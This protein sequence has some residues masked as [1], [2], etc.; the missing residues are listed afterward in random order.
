M[1][2][3]D[4]G[5]ISVIDPVE[6]Y[7]PEYKG[8]K[9]RGCHGT[10]GYGCEGTAPSRP[11]NI[12]D[13]MEHTSG[14]ETSSSSRGGPEPTTLADLAALGAK[15]QLLFDPGTRWNYSNLGYNVLG[16]IIEVVSKQSYDVFLKERIFDPLGMKDT[17]FFVPQEKMNRVATLYTL[18]DSGLTRSPNQLNTQQGPKIPMP[19][20]GIVSTAEDILR[21]NMMMRNKG[22]LDG[23]RVLSSAA[24]TLMTTSHTGDLKAGWVPGV[25][26]GYGYEVVRNADG[27]F[28]YN[29][30]GSF[31]KGGA[32]RTYEWVDPEKDLVGVFMM[33][34]T[35][36][37]GDTADQINSFMAMSAGA[38]E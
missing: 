14:L 6:K 19:A 7:L 21:F 1:V 27:M 34:L 15:T 36:R 31:V 17:Y 16:R 37:G 25:G 29:S 10:S 2:L 26:H 11:I 18:S 4:E 22:T 8:L 13:L 30:I 20:G 24:V 35:N 9:V 3:V 33:Q 32:Y 5:R 38:V 28:R 23:R 12:E